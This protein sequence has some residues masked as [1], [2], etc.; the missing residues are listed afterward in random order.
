MSDVYF[1]LVRQFPLIH[2]RDDARLAEAT[3]VIERLLGKDLD[4]GAEEY[5]DV[6][7]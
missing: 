1:D 5:L 4:K 7:T 6:L 3:E 2:I